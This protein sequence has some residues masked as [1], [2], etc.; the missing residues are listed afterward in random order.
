MPFFCVCIQRLSQLQAEAKHICFT[1]AA[2]IEYIDE[3]G[4]EGCGFFP[5][6]FFDGSG[7]RR[8]YDSIQVRVIGPNIGLAKGMLLVKDG[9]SK[10]QLPQSMIKAPP[11]NTSDETWVAIIM[12]NV[13]PCEKNIQ[14]G[15]Y[16]HPDDDACN[17][18]K[19]QKHKELSEMY[20]RMLLGFGVK[21]EYVSSY[22]ELS[23]SSDRLKHAHLKGVADP[24]FKIP[25]DKV[26]I[27][28]YT[29]NSNGEMEL[30]GKCFKQIY[31]SRSPAVSPGDAKILSVVGEKTEDMNMSDDEWALLCSYRWGTIIFGA[32]HDRL[33][34][35][36]PNI[37]A[38][39][40]LDGD[41]YFVCWDD[42]IVG[43]LLHAKDKLTSKSRKLLF[44]L[45]LPEKTEHSV[46]KTNSFSQGG[47]NWLSL[48]QDKMLDFATQ[49]SESHITGKLYTLCT[50]ASK[51]SGGKI[52]IYDEDACA[53]AQ[54]FKDALD[55][56]KQ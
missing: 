29:S 47:D 37:I 12:K 35:P 11:S 49:N 41:D 23:R 52:D 7:P 38:D 1:T 6:G 13:F 3:N 16:L 46:D 39:G 9:I 30:F 51:K 24:T 18:W 25:G 33:P 50:K 43:H 34:A 32:P 56:Q 4:N 42:N 27:S 48:A 40:D 26:F 17:S 15:R 31:C 55:I 8:K 14:L 2:K 22:T 21:E 5:R 54:A 19:K 28:G 20:Q 10:I 36:L 44:E 45:K 53:Y